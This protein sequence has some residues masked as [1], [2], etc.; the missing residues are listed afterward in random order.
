MVAVVLLGLIMAGCAQK[1][2]ENVNSPAVLAGSVQKGEG[3]SMPQLPERI[4]DTWLVPSQHPRLFVFPDG[5]EAARR[6]VRE[7]DWGKE[8]LEKQQKECAWFI[9]KSDKALRAVVPPPKSLFVYGLSMNLDP[10]KHQ[11]LTWAGWDDP[12]HVRGA[13]GTVYPND[14][15]PDDGSGAIDPATGERYYFIARAN[16][17]VVEQLD[18]KILTALADVAA[19]TGSEEHAHAAAVLLDAIAAVYPTNRRGPLD[20]PTSPKDY[21]RGGRLDRPYYQTARGLI[22]YGHA[23]DL[24]AHSGKLN[25]PSAYINGSIRE[26]VIRNLLWDGGT[27]CLEWAREGYQL[28]NGHADYMQGA[29]VVGVLLDTRAFCDVMITGPLSLKAML[30]INIDRNGFY[31]ETSPA[32]A[33]HARGLY[34]NLAEMLEAMRRLGWVNVPLAYAHPAMSLF[35]T[36]PFNRQEVGGH[37]PMIGDAGPAMFAYSPM[38]RR[39]IQPRVYEDSFIDGQIDASWIRMARGVQSDAAAQLLVDIYGKEQPPKPPA[40]RWSIYHVSP[41][42]ITNLMRCQPNPDRF[43]T[44]STFYGAKGLALLRGGKG[45]QRYGAQ[46]FFGPAHNHAQR[47]K[48]TW[49]FFA[50]G[51]EWSY[52]PGYYNK[53]YRMGFTSQTVAHQAVLVDGKSHTAKDGGTGRLLA[54]L[55]EDDVQW[56]MAAHD[57]VYYQDRA[58]SRF[59]RFIGQV[60]NPATG[61]LGYWLDV[62][63]VEGGA[64]RDD[65]FHTCMRE[66]K[67]DVDLKPT[68]APAMFGDEDLGRKIN[69]DLY[70]EGREKEGFYWVAPGDGYGFLGSPR[71]AAMER[72]VRVVMTSPVWDAY[73]PVSAVVVTDLLGAKDRQI[74]V[75]QGPQFGSLHSVPYIIRRDTGKGVSVFAKVIRIVADVK[76]DPIASVEQQGDDTF[77]VTWR[78]GRVDRWQV[79]GNGVSLRCQ[80]ADGSLMAEYASPCTRPQGTVLAVSPAGAPATLKIKWD[81]PFDAKPGMPLVMTPPFGQAATWRIAAVDGDRVRLEDATLSMA[82]TDLVPVAG[83]AGWFA[84]ASG[85]SRF[86]GNVACATGKAVYNGDE[87]VGRITAVSDDYKRIRIEG[88]GKALRAEKFTARFLEVGEGD[89]VTVV[90]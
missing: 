1:Q 13:D 51:A 17:F 76:A 78:S 47:E 58:V 64:Q 80:Q 85:V 35:L 23:I 10:V 44:R 66:A 74:I 22:N 5:L 87:L 69:N 6:V 81:E 20:Y 33:N 46:L 86:I 68:G 32:Y 75:A 48:M 59:E 57:G 62:A 49:T 43:N 16:G 53:H 25:Q 38:R 21:D 28:H 27:Y 42:M 31:Y 63:I 56:A 55:D 60:R 54:W 7:T 18:Q 88:T 70:V 2:P 79:S 84:T 8:Y 90:R 65:S 9:G 45:E 19:L 83:E 29:S 50:R 14:K 26:H 36:E 11:R 3:F 71:Q 61:N 67:L 15:W 12:W 39:P 34:V 77:S 4:P 52:D 89:R 82:I 72:N 30:D 73:K 40:D 37:I 41:A 24:I